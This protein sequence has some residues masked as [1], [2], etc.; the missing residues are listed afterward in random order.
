MLVEWSGKMANSDQQKN[1]K[2][3]PT[4]V[5]KPI[6]TLKNVPA[7]KEQL[8]KNIKNFK[9]QNTVFTLGISVAEATKILNK[10]SEENDV[11]IIS[12]AQTVQK[13][14]DLLLNSM[15]AFKNSNVRVFDYEIARRDYTKALNKHQKKLNK[16]KPKVDPQNVV[17]K[18]ISKA[19]TGV[20]SKAAG[21][22]EA[23]KNQTKIYNPNPETGGVFRGGSPA[24]IKVENVGKLVESKAKYVGGIGDTL[25]V[26]EAIVLYNTG[27]PKEATGKI[28]SIGGAKAGSAV[29]VSLA[30]KLCP[31]MVKGAKHPVV[32]AVVGASCFGAMWY[33]GDKF[34]GDI[35]EDVGE[36]LYSRTPKQQIDD[37]IK[38]TEEY[39]VEIYDRNIIY[40]D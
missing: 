4:L 13:G 22:Y 8:A 29:G 32:L 14:T 16:S 21:A 2:G 38:L 5:L 27:K 31:Q 17:G 40:G 11:G 24:R 35:G 9:N 33:Y 1:S 30:G 28:A 20:S 7:S 3:K 15:G 18:Y 12:D 34:G 6:K 25:D 26:A 36:G 37:N 19:A 10:K 39:G 23:T